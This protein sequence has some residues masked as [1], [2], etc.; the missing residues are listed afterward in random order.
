MRIYEVRAVDPL[1]FMLQNVFVASKKGAATERKELRTYYGSKV[2]L[3]TEEHEFE[4]KRPDILRLLNEVAV[5][6]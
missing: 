4:P 3:I 5:K 6:S 2:E 1:G